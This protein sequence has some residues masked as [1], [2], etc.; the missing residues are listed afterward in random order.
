MRQSTFDRLMAHEDYPSTL[1]KCDSCVCPEYVGVGSYRA[2]QI[3]ALS[4]AL[5]TAKIKVDVKVVYAPR[6]K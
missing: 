2:L 6:P 1:M 3:L 4:D 5:Q